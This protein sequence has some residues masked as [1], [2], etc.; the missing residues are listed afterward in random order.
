MVSILVLWVICYIY[1][2][3]MFYVI[4][5]FLEGND[6]FFGNNIFEIFVCF[7]YVYVF[8]G[9]SC[10]VCVFEVYME[11][12]ILCFIRFG[13]IFRIRSVMSYFE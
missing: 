4:I 6:L 7:M 1:L 5:E 12:R 8:D 10:F 9:Y 11:V 3:F 2:S 13:W